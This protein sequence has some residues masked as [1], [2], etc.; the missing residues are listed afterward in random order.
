[1]SFGI[2][3]LASK[4]L[5]SKSLL[6][7]KKQNLENKLCH[8]L[9]ISEIK[10]F[11]MIEEII[12]L[13]EEKEKEKEKKIP[14]Y[15]KNRED[16][17]TKFRD[18]GGR[19]VFSECSK[20]LDEYIRKILKQYNIRIHKLTIKKQIKFSFTDYRNF[21]KKLIIDIYSD[22]IPRRTKK[23]YKNESKNTFN[24]SSIKKAIEKE[25]MNENIK[26]KILNILFNKTNF[27]IILKAF[28][29]D[30]ND[31]IVYDSDLGKNIK[32]VLEGFKTFK[33]CLNDRYDEKSKGELKKW[34][35]ELMKEESVNIKPRKHRN[36]G[37]EK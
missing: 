30:K 5:Y 29:D 33:D 35:I 26:I 10:D 7:E 19:S 16:D 25:K 21:C 28:L 6:Q 37:K 27:N 2:I 9:N 15:L 23:E 31:I 13:Y 18:I 14:N 20:S 4:Y 1:M 17:K 12:K 22:S 8:I 34:I 36:L 11:D 24:E 3:T 32:I